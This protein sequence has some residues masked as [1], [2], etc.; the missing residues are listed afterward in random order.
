MGRGQSERMPRPHLHS[1]HLTP[2]HCKPV[3]ASIPISEAKAIADRNHCK[4][5]IIAAFDED[6]IT[7][8]ITYGKTLTDCEQAAQGGNFIK[9]ALGWPDEL[10]HDKPKRIKK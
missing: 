3:A 6:G 1:P 9:K 7:H 5:V 2:L 10:C 4:Q 8:I